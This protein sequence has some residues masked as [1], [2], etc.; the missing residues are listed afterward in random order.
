[1]ILGIRGIEESSVYQGIFAKGRAEGGQIEEARRYLLDLGRKRL[2]EPGDNVLGQ[3]AAIDDLDR[4]NRLLD[5]ILDATTWE[6]LLASVVGG[7]QK[8]NQKGVRNQKDKTGPD[9]F[10]LR[11]KIKRFLTP[12]ISPDPFNFLGGAVARTRPSPN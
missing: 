1:M 6:E 12:L 4:L 11:K 2:G 9:P 7:N 5:R 10:N 8:G 3:V